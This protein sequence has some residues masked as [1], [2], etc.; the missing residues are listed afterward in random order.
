MQ[1]GEP[2]VVEAEQVEDRRVQVVDRD[3]VAAALQ[4]IS[5]V[6]PWLM[7]P[8]TPPP[9]IQTRKPYGLWSRPSPFSETGMRPNSPPQTTKRRCRAARAA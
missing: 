1:V 9:A 4:P 5:S 3:R 8:L 6:A 2:F 7:P